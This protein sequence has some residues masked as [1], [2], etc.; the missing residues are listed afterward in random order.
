MTSII[1][2]AGW[3]QS[4][5]SGAVPL[6]TWNTEQLRGDQI[7]EDSCCCNLCDPGHDTGMQLKDLCATKK[8]EINK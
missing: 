3:T 1:L 8:F 2:P 4:V 6:L 5:R 7:S